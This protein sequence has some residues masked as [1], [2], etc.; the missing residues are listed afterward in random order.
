MAAITDLIQLRHSETDNVEDESVMLSAL[1]ASGLPIAQDEP[2]GRGRP[3]LYKPEYAA[4][5]AKLCKLG[6]TDPDLAD[7]FGVT[8]R[9]IERW[10]SAHEDFC[11]AVIVAKDEADNAVERSLYQRAVGYEQEAVKIFMPAGA[12]APV[13]APYRERIAPDTAAAI[14]WLKNRRKDQWRDRIENEHT[15]KLT[16]SDQF[17]DLLRELRGDRAKMIDA[18]V[19]DAAE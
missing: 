3:T 7:F 2:I 12:E 11:R 5:A 17:E 14:F 19:L 4:Q 6:A 18:Q 1:E 16:L 10:R 8:R 9:T 15:H 13:Y